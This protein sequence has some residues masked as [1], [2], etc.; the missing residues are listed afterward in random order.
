MLFVNKVWFAFLLVLLAIGV[1]RAQSTLTVPSELVQFPDL[2]VHNAKIVTM[3]D[4]TPNGPP[5]RIV[6]AMAI[7]GDTIQFLGTNVQILRVAGPQTRK[8]DLKSRTVVP[9]LI[10]TH[11][12]LH[13]GFVSDWARN[14][15]EEVVRY[16]KGFSVAGKTY[17]ELT[18]GIELV[19]KEGMASAPEGQWATINLPGGGPSG[20]GIGTHYLKEK[21]M[22]RPRL[23]QWAPNRPVYVSTS[24]GEF[25]MNTA[26]RDAYMKIF[27]VAATDENEMGTLDTN[28]QISR[29]LIVEQYFKTRVPL[30][31]NIFENGL[32]YFAAL[33]FTGFSSHIV[34]YPVH[35]AYMKLAREERMPVRFGFA[36]RF[37]QV[38]AVDIS[39]CFARLGDMAGMGNK[40]FW[41]VGVTL[42]ALDFD[43]PAFCTTMEATPEVKAT[44]K[45]NSDPGTY[46]YQGIHTALR[47]H[48][49]YVV[50]HVMGDKS[51]DNFLG[52][53]DRVMKED[54]S[55]DLE[56][57]R[58]RR[59]SADHCGWF[60][61]QDQIPLMAKWNI[62]VSCGPK[63]LDDQGAYIPNFYGEKYANRVGPA[64]S[65]LKGGLN[66]STEG[67][68]QVV[69][70]LNE[71]KENWTIFA[72]Y[73]PYLTRKRSDGVVLAKEEALNRVQLMKTST[74]W[75]AAYML[76]EKEIGSLETGKLA[77]FVVFNK[78]YF[79]IPEG[80]IPTVI[81][82][83]VVVGG[84]T[85]VLRSELAKELGLNAVGPQLKFTY[86]IPK[87][88]SGESE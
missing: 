5:G 46:Y 42:G 63:E 51:M 21:Q 30:L 27:E 24:D 70:K 81:P 59:F 66:L 86:E 33:G 71:T 14:N 47:S 35:D 37:C 78:D 13:D 29:T 19:I 11:T 38:M 40:Y 48:L 32:K 31:A 25:L 74:S 52:L 75:A 7:R 28:P 64:Q 44:E 80:D 60:P 23:D 77:D 68:Q 39:G 69:P 72:R 6:E 4:K 45:C 3:D 16:R 62:H 12:H 83:M 8:I 58:S 36:H 26:A 82:L 18:K 9:G 41:N 76:K 53:I 84:K 22:D 65:I 56:Y 20:L 54:P 34:G 1:A 15:P 67:G 87:A 10:D 17:E 50:N 73:F 85:I 49:R 55:M 79:T 2:I 43:A 61:R 88:R 57:V